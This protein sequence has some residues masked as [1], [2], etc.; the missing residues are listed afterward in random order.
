MRETKGEVKRGEKRDAPLPWSSLPA[1]PLAGNSAGGE[2]M[3]LEVH[4]GKSK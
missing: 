2:G 3:E 1:R 4:E